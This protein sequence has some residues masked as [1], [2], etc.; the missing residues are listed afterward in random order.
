MNLVTLLQ[1]AYLAAGLLLAAGYG[2]QLQRAWREPLATARAWAPASLL[3]WALC[4]G[5]ALGYVALVA[6][7]ALLVLVV[8]LDVLGRIAMLVLLWRAQRLAGGRRAIACPRAAAQGLLLALALLLAG[9][10]GA[11]APP[12]ATPDRAAAR[13]QALNLL[14][15]PLLEPDGAPAWVDPARAYECPEPPQVTVD[16][17]PLVPGAAVPARAFVLDWQGRGCALPR[18][19]AWPIAGHARLWVFPG[20]EAYSAIVEADGLQLP[21]PVRLQGSFSAELRLLPAASP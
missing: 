15:V 20:D 4:R 2:P 8:G 9:C 10:R 1:A 7:D 12:P 21:G 6:R 5:V 17:V 14:L 11:G 18:Q 16:G 3:T 19:S 13:A